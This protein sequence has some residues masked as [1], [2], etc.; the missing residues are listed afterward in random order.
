MSLIRSAACALSVISVSGC[1]A[2]EEDPK[3]EQVAQASAAEEHGTIRL[4][5]GC[6]GD[7]GVALEGEVIVTASGKLLFRVWKTDGTPFEMPTTLYLFV[8]DG[9]TCGDPPNVAKATAPV[10]VG[11]SVQTIELSLVDYQGSWS[12]GESKRFW[13][14]KSEGP[15]RSWRSTGAVDITKK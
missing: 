5:P 10:V 14:G 1:I 6:A 8:G 11:Q 9:P 7:N 4:P 12:T 13:I 3:I 2:L 15:H